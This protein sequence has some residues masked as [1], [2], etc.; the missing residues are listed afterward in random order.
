LTQ[1]DEISKFAEYS[2]SQVGIKV[3]LKEGGWVERWSQN[4]HNKLLG[5]VEEVRKQERSYTTNKKAEDDWRN[6]RK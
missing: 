6:P 4:D 2:S 1:T 5:L 3:S